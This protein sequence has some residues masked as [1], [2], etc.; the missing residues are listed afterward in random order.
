[1]DVFHVLVPN[2][3][4]HHICSSIEWL[5]FGSV[6]LQLTLTAS[7]NGFTLKHLSPLFTGLSFSVLS[8]TYRNSRTFLYPLSDNVDVKPFEAPQRSA[9]IK[10]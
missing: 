9:K 8:T 2:R 6:L 3:A 10:I 1:M 5:S 7:N 4:T